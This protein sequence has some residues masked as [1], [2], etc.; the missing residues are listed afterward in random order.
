MREEAVGS[1]PQ[2]PPHP[3]PPPQF[4]SLLLVRDARQSCRYYSV[5]NDIVIIIIHIVLSWIMI[6]NNV[7]TYI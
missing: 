1:N 2:P 6:L 5:R 7:P 3:P 4:S